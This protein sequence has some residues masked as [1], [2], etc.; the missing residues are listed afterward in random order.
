[1]WW[2]GWVVSDFVTSGGSAGGKRRGRAAARGQ[3]PLQIASTSISNGE[4]QDTRRPSTDQ[5]GSTV[6]KGR[7]G[8]TGDAAIDL[9]YTVRGMAPALATSNLRLAS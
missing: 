2:A 8:R 7:T 4:T 5:P 9:S 1:M 3:G 6:K